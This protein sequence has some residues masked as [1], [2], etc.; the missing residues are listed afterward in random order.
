MN[1]IAQFSELPH[2]QTK[3]QDHQD[4]GT[5][6]GTAGRIREGLCDAPRDF[7]PP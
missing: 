4:I 5:G 7:G 2:A 1:W 6:K 3:Q